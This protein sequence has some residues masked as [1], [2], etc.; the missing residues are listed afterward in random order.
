MILHRLDSERRIK[1]SPLRIVLSFDF[2]Q[3]FV[4][5]LPGFCLAIRRALK[6]VISRGF[7]NW[8]KNLKISPPRVNL[9]YMHSKYCTAH[10][11]DIEWL[12]VMIKTMLTD[13]KQLS[14]E[15]IDHVVFKYVSVQKPAVKSGGGGWRYVS[16]HSPPICRHINYRQLRY[17]KILRCLLH[18]CHT[19]PLQKMTL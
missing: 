19:K 5:L 13:M 12:C 10:P 6:L 2:N 14:K 15:G 17:K 11:F 16:P 4:K 8:G 18:I 9:G 3:L 7:A 1:V